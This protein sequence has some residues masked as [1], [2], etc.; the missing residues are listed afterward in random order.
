M[1]RRVGLTDGFVGD[2]GGE[3]GALD[4]QEGHFGLDAERDSMRTARRRALA[5][6]RGLTRGVNEL[7]AP[8]TLFEVCT[9]DAVVV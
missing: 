2:A 6:A 1:E 3:K 5:Q 4:M 9:D 8:L 7:R